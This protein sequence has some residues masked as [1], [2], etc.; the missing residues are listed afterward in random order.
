M[1]RFWLNL[2]F[3]TITCFVLVNVCAVIYDRIS[4]RQTEDPGG[5]IYDAIKRAQQTTNDKTMVIGDSVAHQL[6]TGYAPPG[7][8]SLGTNQAIGMCGQYMMA[9]SALDH[10]PDIKDVILAYQ[11]DSFTNNLDQVFFFNYFVKPFYPI[12]RFRADMS[13]DVIAVIDRHPA[14]RLVVFP[15]FRYTTMLGDLDYSKDAPPHAFTYLAPVSIEYL[16]R[17]SNL[18]D[19]R[20]VRLHVV[21]T[22]ISTDRDYD[23]AVFAK[24]VTDAHLDPLFTNYAASVRRVDPQLLVDHVHFTDENIAA[25]SKIFIEMLQRQLAP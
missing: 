14:A 7:I 3:F 22:P 25:N 5:E 12:A 20:H 19:Q 16:H 2:T 11:P 21:S 17:L 24:E 13:P 18:C 4:P 9:H 8:L 15:L 1:Q 10:H 6:L 23:E